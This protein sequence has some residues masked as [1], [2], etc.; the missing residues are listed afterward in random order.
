VTI[1]NH[2]R[3]GKALEVLKSGLEPFVEREFKVKY[4]DD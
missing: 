1:T 3:G 2:E 4:A